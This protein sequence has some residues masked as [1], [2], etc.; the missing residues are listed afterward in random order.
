MRVE[1]ISSF[2]S[3][4]KLESPRGKTDHATLKGICD[5]RKLK[6]DYI[7]FCSHTKFLKLFQDSDEKNVFLIFDEKTLSSIEDLSQLDGS[8]GW[9]TVKSVPLA[10]SFLSKPFYDEYQAQY[11]D[12]VDGR[13]TG[14]ATIHPSAVIAENVFIGA[15]VIIE[16]GVVLH[17]QVVILSNSKI[18]KGSCL[19]PNVTIMQNCIIGSECRMHSGSVIGSDGFG[20]NFSEGV[21]HKVWH[22]GGVIMGN[23]VEIGSN[24]SV[25]QGTFSPTRIGDGTKLD[26]LVQVGHNAILKKGVVMCGQAGLAGSITVGDFTVMGG[27]VAV[28][29]DL[30]IGSACQIAGK[31]GVISSLGDKEVVGGFPARP[32]REWL[33]GVAYLRKITLKKEK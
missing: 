1:D 18:G 7:Y 29:P 3:S 32:M 15:N 8:L 31:A 17:S 5:G 2:D 16:E 24:S 27:Q 10:M 21:H 6:S 14:T 30:T 9:A 23:N 26:N 4:F 33:K 13:K 25:D 20:Y 28:A 22:T 19:Y 11:N 12:A